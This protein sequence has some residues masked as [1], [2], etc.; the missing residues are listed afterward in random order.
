[1]LL[2]APT[3]ISIHSFQFLLKYPKMRSKEPSAFCSQPS[4]TGAMFRPVAGCCAR[5][6]A[7]AVASAATTRAALAHRRGILTAAS[8]GLPRQAAR[9]CREFWRTRTVG[10]PERFALQSG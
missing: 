4:Y 9:A 2:A 3:G 8:P 7:L 6:L 10:N 1:M 5:G